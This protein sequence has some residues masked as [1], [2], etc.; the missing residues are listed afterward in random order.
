MLSDAVVEIDHPSPCPEKAVGRHDHR[1]SSS[2]GLLSQTPKSFADTHHAGD[3]DIVHRALIVDDHPI[4]RRLPAVILGDAGWITDEAANKAARECG[5]ANATSDWRSLISNPDIDIIDITAPNALHKELA[6][7]A[8]AAGWSGAALA[9]ETVTVWFTKGFYKGE[10]D[11]LL[12][13]VDKFQ[14]ATGVKV[15]L[16]LYAT[17]D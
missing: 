15:E 12:A 6:L 1:V 17:E 14:K 2:Q 9:Q 11:A 5:F 8:I 4:N 7:A 10:D 16:S 13:V 3:V